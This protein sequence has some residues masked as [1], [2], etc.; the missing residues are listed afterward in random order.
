MLTFKA[1]AP[2]LSNFMLAVPP[3]S[4]N[5]PTEFLPVVSILPSDV[6]AV[7]T[8]PVTVVVPALNIPAFLPTALV[9]FISPLFS[10]LEPEVIYIPMLPAPAISILPIISFVL[11]VSFLV[12]LL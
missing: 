5:N 12:L 3:F 11:A 7:S 4:L 8:A 9:S 1:V 10:P 6:P 2:P